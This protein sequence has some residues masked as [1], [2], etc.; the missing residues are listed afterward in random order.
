MPPESGPQ[1]GRNSFVEVLRSEIIAESENLN[2]W[3]KQLSDQGAIE[4]L[5]AMETWLKGIRSFFKTE[6]LP[7]SA[8]E[9]AELAQRGFASEINIVRQ[10]VRTCELQACEVLKPGMGAGFEFEEFI[11]I[12]MRKD[13]LPD[14]HLTR[15][16]EQLTPRDSV[17]QLLLSLND[18]RVT[19]DALKDQTGLDYQLYVSLGR[20]FDRE[21]KGCRYVDMLLSQHLRLQYDLIENKA[22]A[23][24]LQ[25]ISE[26]SVRRNMATTLL[27]LFRFLK[28]LKF[29]STDLKRDQPLQKH[30]VL[31]SLLHEEM[32]ILSDFL[33]A[34]FLKNRLPDNPLQNAAELVAY[35]LKAEAQR[36][37]D[38]EL[39]SISRETDPAAIYMHIENGHGL[40]HNCCQS[41]ILSLI[42]AVDRKFDPVVLFPS[43]AESLT[44]AEKLRQDLWDLRHWLM[45]VLANKTELDSGSVVERLLTF[46]ENSLRSL[47]YRDW[48]EFETFSD[49]LS[50]AT[51]FIELRTLIRKFVDFLENLIQEVS[52]RSVFQD[53]QP[54]P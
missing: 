50:I 39:I 40:L 28:Y 15:M 45:D 5:F 18:F 24:V 51:N 52:K 20:S 8:A 6:H 29:V 33:R 41:G 12:Q 13:R 26:D 48:A 19:M 47:M 30:L 7:L 49:A 11:E 54:L 4:S 42:Q 2:A 25:G 32:G 3:V 44:A 35:S 43:R 37:L 1:G 27:Y 21:L 34:R 22:L 23:G 16:V 9:K 53:K 36:V 38:R 10:A 31:F 46:K 14:F 17:S